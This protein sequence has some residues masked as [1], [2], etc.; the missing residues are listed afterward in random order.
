MIIYGIIETGN[1]YTTYR[2]EDEARGLDYI[3]LT[4]NTTWLPSDYTDQ[5]GQNWISVERLTDEFCKLVKATGMKK[6]ELAKRCG[7]TPT[8]FS[9][10]CTGKSPVPP[11]VWK[12]IERIAAQNA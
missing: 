1:I 3:P 2:T 11:L 8:Q 9:R 6:S 10:Y 5:S 4:E 7:I 12:E